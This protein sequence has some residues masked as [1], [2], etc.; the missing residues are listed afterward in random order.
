MS[1]PMPTGDQYRLIVESSP[2]MIWRA[3]TDSLCNY[4]NATWLKFTGRTLEQE[5][6]NGW[7]EGVHPEDFDRC[8]AIYLENFEARRAFEMEYRL[9]R[10]DGEWRW[11]NDIGVPF[12][13]D[14]GDFA[15]FIGSCMDVTDRVEGNLLREMAQIDGLTRVFNRQHFENL[16]RIEFHRSERYAS[17]LCL[18]MVDIDGFKRINDTYGH[19]AGDDVLRA[20]ARLFR[21]NVRDLDLVGRYGGDEFI[22]L[23]P[24]TA[25]PEAEALGFRLQEKTGELK[26]HFP[27]QGSAE[28]DMVSVSISLGLA[29]R[30]TQASLQDLA[31]EADRRLYEAKEVRR[32]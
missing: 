2:N 9:R 4:F 28:H 24:N 31:A 21:A 16:A 5:N 10:Q 15:G 25:R 13:D 18:F 30:T 32:G 8:L 11:I 22:L 19:Q 23:L 3:G 26:F 1:I 29:E 6:G 12:F 20:I 17:P 14:S 7:A 27:R